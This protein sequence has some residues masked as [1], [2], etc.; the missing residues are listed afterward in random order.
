MSEHATTGLER[1]PSNQSKNS[2]KLFAYCIKKLRPISK[3]HGI[4]ITVFALL[5]TF[6]LVNGFVLST[7]D[8]DS[9]VFGKRLILIITAAYVLT[10][11]VFWILLSSLAKWA[12]KPVPDTPR[13]VDNHQLLSNY[14]SQLSDRKFFVIVFG[15][16]LI[17]KILI[18]IAYSAIITH[19]SFHLI[20]QATGFTPFYAQHPIINVIAVTPFMELGKLLGD[21]H[22]GIYLWALFQTFAYTACFAYVILFLR[23][24]KAR[25]IIQ[26]LSMVAFSTMPIFAMAG[27]FVWSDILFSSFA[28][29]FAILSYKLMRN[30]QTFYRRK[31]SVF[32]FVLIGFLFAT[33][34]NN[35]YY[36]F[37]IAIPFLIIALRK[38]WRPVVVLVVAPLIIATGYFQILIPAVA[39]PITAAESLSVPLQ[40]IARSVFEH[41]GEMNPERIAEIT[42]FLNV[43]KTVTLYKPTNSDPIKN[44]FRA[45]GGETYLKEHTIEFITLWLNTLR[46]YPITSLNATLYN[47]KG[48][49]YLFDAHVSATTDVIFSTARPNA[50]F[51]SIYQDEFNTALSDQFNKS[52]QASL[53]NIYKDHLFPQLM[54]LDCIP[55]YF[56][57]F[58]LC[59]FVLLIRRD[60]KT[61]ISLAGIFGVIV[62]IFAGPVADFRYLFCLPLLAPVLFAFVCNQP[63]PETKPTIPEP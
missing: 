25:S 1:P 20:Q 38:Y 59:V 55:F 51:E 41:G 3:R 43:D 16:L 31:S 45:E 15:I 10:F 47:T 9:F 32:F 61:L 17:P 52:K 56:W 23:Q 13:R 54:V 27:I 24:I 8:V 7:W 57:L 34:R 62:T 35:G 60:S 30:P 49:W 28:V 50:N 21:Y 44:S 26:I 22:I 46:D 29:L 14:F 5:F 2:A 48:Y 37:I 11:S 33:W 4:L 53:L 63:F 36:A 39:S 12:I 18:W 6:M 40:Q 58:V 42:P 19:D